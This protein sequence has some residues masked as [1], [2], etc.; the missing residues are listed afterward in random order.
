M[1]GGRGSL[2]IRVARWDLAATALWKVLDDYPRTIDGAFWHASSV[3]DRHH[4]LWLDGT[5]MNLPFLEEQEKQDDAEAVNQLLSISFCAT[6]Q[7]VFPCTLTTKAA[8]LRGRIR[9][10]VSRL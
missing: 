8:R 9:R 7:V 4:R 3:E 5:Y 10:P 6:R 1:S 2:D